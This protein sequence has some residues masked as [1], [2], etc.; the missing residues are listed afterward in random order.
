M[1]TFTLL[2]KKKKIPVFIHFP[3]FIQKILI[4]HLA[5]ARHCSRQLVYAQNKMGKI[6]GLLELTFYLRSKIGNKLIY[7]IS[8]GKKNSEGDRLYPGKK[9]RRAGFV[10]LKNKNF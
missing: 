6:P 5:N 7:I 9:G 1:C 10:F 2:K 8:V 4:E 3:P